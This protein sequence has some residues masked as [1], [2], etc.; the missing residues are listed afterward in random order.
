MNSFEFGYYGNDIVAYDNTLF[1]EFSV[2]L[3]NPKYLS[4]NLLLSK[5]HLNSSE[6]QGRGGVHVFNYN[7]QALVLR[8][9][10]R[11]GAMA[12]ISADKYLWTGLEQTRAISELQM[13]ADMQMMGLPVPMPVAAHIHRAGATYTA[14]IVTK[15]I[16]NTQTLSSLLCKQ[17]LSNKTWSKLGQV[18]RRMHKKKCNHADLNAHNILLDNEL[19]IFLIDFDKSEFKASSGKWEMKNI[20]RLKRSLEKLANADKNFNYTTEDFVLFRRGYAA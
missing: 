16:P 1:A 17:K 2:D 10:Y 19:N 6:M 5:D 4:D 12:N 15:Y 3:F 13:L 9:Y 20:E 11:G 7:D 14:D 18:I 8:H